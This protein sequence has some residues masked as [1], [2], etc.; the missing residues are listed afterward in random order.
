MRSEHT[1]GVGGGIV[2]RG[3]ET[4]SPNAPRFLEGKKENVPTR[5]MVPSLRWRCRPLKAWATSSTIFRR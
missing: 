2:V 4:A 3:D 5:P 1:R